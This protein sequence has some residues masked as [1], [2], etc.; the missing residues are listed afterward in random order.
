MIF[1]SQKGQGL[2]EYALLILLV[3]IAV[4]VLLALFGTG[5]GNMFSNIVSNI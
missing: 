3:G 1:S 2:V 4:I 5:V